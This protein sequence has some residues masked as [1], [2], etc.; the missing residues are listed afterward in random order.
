MLTDDERPTYACKCLNIR[1]H[2]VPPIHVP[3]AATD[4]DFTS[5][6]VGDDG[7]SIVSFKTYDIF[8]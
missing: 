5:V 3:P 8:A 2:P 4:P 7:I 6:H 1:I